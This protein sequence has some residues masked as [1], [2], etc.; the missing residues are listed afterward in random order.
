MTKIA[1]SIIA[2]DA[3]R[4]ADEVKAVIAAGADWLHM[5]I[6]DGVFVPNI[7]YGPWIH[8]ALKKLSTV[9]LDT[10]LMVQDPDRYLE[11]FR[12]AGAE[13]LTVHVEA[14]IHIHRT[15]TKIRSLG[16]KAGL[17]LN[18]GTPLQAA[19]PLLDNLDLILVMS[20]NPGF[21]GQAFIPAAIERV[22]HLDAWRR[23]RKLNFLIEVDGGVAGDNAAALRAAGAD[24]LVAGSSVYKAKDYAAAITG[25]RGH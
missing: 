15:L 21:A 24:I 22:R 14:S 18:P 12:N 17:A 8:A 9:P 6:M 10:H 25:L 5:D 20:V 7:T 13:I 11:D 16:A 4:L 19:E 23:E 3:T 2:A 1:P